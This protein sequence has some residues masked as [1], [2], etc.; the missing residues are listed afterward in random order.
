MKLEVA[1]HIFRSKG[2]TSTEHSIENDTQTVQIRAVVNRS[3]TDLFR[4]SISPGSY[5]C[6]GGMGLPFGVQIFDDSKIGDLTLSI[7]VDQ[8]IGGFEIPMHQTM[9]VNVGQP[10]AQIEE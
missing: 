1:G 10:L 5:K 7:L 2:T 4:R 3:A 8:D 9:T 6:S